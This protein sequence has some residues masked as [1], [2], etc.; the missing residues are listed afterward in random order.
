MAPHRAGL[1]A[2]MLLGLLA[3]S[4]MAAA[5]RPG[6]SKRRLH[7]VS[8]SAF[9]S[10]TGGANVNAV[11]QA[12]GDGSTPT[13]SNVVATGSAPGTVD[14]RQTATS[15]QQLNKACDQAT[16]QWVSGGGSGGNGGSSASASASSS[17]GP[18]WF[19]APR[20]RKAP[21][22][23]RVERDGQGRPWGWDDASCALRNDKGEPL[24]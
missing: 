20:C 21:S 1:V 14:C 15:G 16:G 17:A 3:G 18:S 6:P 13:S 8:A 7:Q 10:S 5:A 4:S 11:S 9:A 2:L 19:S 12:F 22:A 23:Y 24:V